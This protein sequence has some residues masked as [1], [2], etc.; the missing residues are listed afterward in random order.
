MYVVYIIYIHVCYIYQYTFQEFAQS[1][2]GIIFRLKV[3]TGRSVVSFSAF[4]TEQEVILGPNTSFI[5]FQAATLENDGFYYVTLQ[6]RIG[7]YI[8]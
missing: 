1:P 8:F 4:P 3:L 7:K 6:E 2:G 5:V